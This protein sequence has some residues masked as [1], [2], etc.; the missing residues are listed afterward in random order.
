[1]KKIYFSSTYWDFSH[2]KFINIYYHNIWSEASRLRDFEMKIRKT[3]K[4]E[5]LN[6]IA[7]ISLVF[8]LIFCDNKK[9]LKDILTL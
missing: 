9:W 8:G 6:Q 7:N 5:W 2:G 1:M 4:N 3:F